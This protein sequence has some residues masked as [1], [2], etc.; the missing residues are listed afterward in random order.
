MSVSYLQGFIVFYQEAKRGRCNGAIFLLNVK[1][2]IENE[3]IA[4]ISLA[5][6][7]IYS[8]NIV[9]SKLC[10]REL[11]IS[12]QER[13]PRLHVTK[14]V[15]TEIK[16]VQLCRKQNLK[17]QLVSCIS[18]VFDHLLQCEKHMFS[19]GMRTATQNLVK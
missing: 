19:V 6:K 14:T 16:A 13:R 12:G 18:E 11:T 7:F 8:E 1:C 3:A 4:E 17:E 2:G 10:D 5:P 15:I 9:G